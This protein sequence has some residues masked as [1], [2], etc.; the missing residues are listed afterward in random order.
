[1]TRSTAVPGLGPDDV[2][3]AAR[4][5]FD[6]LAPHHGADWS[7]RAWGLEWTC[8][9]TIEHVIWALDRYAISLAYPSPEPAPRPATEQPTLSIAELLELMVRRAGILAVVAGAAAPATLG[10]HVCG[11]SDSTGFAALGVVETI[12]HTDDILAGLGQQWVPPGELCRRAGA[13]L[14]P[15]APVDTDPTTTLFW[16]TGRRDPPN[17]ARREARWIYHTAPLSEWDG[18]VKRWE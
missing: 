16:A 9:H 14:F 13:R 7:V 2:L 11:P 10:H 12:V 18:T 8:R 4:A 3:R 1:M 5:S 15:W 17:G 6:A